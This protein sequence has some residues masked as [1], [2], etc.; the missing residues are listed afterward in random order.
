[1]TPRDPVTGAFLEVDVTNQV[2]SLFLR[3]VLPRSGFEV[4]GEFGREDHSWDKRDLILEPDHESALGLGFRKAW[5]RGGR[6]IFALR[7]EI[8][9][10]RTPELWRHRTEGQ[11]YTHNLVRQGH[12]NRG[13]VLGADIGIN[14]S[15]AI[16][17]ALDRYTPNG[18][19]SVSWR[20]D[21]RRDGGAPLESPDVQH[22]VAIERT[23]TRGP[24][25][26]ALQT[27]AAYDFHR[28]FGADARNYHSA[29]SVRW[30]PWRAAR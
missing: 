5:A 9:D 6:Q 16:V 25:E 27:G 20:S 10:F 24:L 23:F 4:Y 22:D 15:Q 3:W 21:V 28:D 17:L 12:T 11:V 13:Q 2:A 19:L 14:S 18:R 7:G 1:M 8:L 30:W 26:V 29:V